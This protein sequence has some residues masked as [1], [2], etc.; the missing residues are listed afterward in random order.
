MSVAATDR[1]SAA[2]PP[3]AAAQPPRRARRPA[4]PT[5]DR[6]RAGAAR[7]HELVQVARTR[8][9]RTRSARRCERRST[10]SATRRCRR[11]HFDVYFTNSLIV[12][13][14]RVPRHDAVGDGGLRARR[15]RLPR[16]HVARA[17]LRAR[18]H[19][20]DP[21]RHRRILKL[22]KKLGLL[23]GTRLGTCSGPLRAARGADPG[24]HGDGDPARDLH[25]EPV[26]AT[27]AEGSEERGARRR[28]RRVPR[29]LGS[30]CRSSDRASR[31]S[32]SS[33]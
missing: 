10:S 24:L 25:H 20:P 18:D 21:P 8:S 33:R 13:S 22:T 11:S 1:S 2:A 32:R 5:R 14:C 7:H 9:S 26:H 3:A 16:E 31:R 27:G 23:S 6:A 17:L 28:S 19:D 12:T 30:C 4:S 15:V 29:V